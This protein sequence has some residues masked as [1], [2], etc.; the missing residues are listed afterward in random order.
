MIVLDNYVEPE[1]RIKSGK[2]IMIGR[3]EIMLN[4]FDYLN[5]LAKLPTTVLLRGETGTGKELCAKAL[6]YNGD[7]FRSKNE[8]VVVNCAGIPSELL[9]SELFGYV[10]GAFTGAYQT[11][12]GKFQHANGGTIFLDEIGDM[13]LPLQSKILRVIQE[14]QVIRIGSNKTEEIDVRIVTATNN[15]LE[16]KM[17]TGKFRKD[18]YFRLNVAPVT[19]PLLRDRSD[20]IPLI[21]E[22]F[23]KKYNEIH[24]SSL[25]GFS[26][27]AIER[28]MSFEWNGNVRELENVVERLFVLN[29][30]GIIHADDLCFNSDMPKRISGNSLNDNERLWFED[31]VY[32]I[33]P[34]ELS[35]L[36]GAMPY[37]C[38]RKRINNPRVHFT[39]LNTTK[40]ENYFII[41]LTPENIDLFFNDRTT[42]DY[43]DLKK[44]VVEDDFNHVVNHP[45][46]LFSISDL[47][48]N[49]YTL[50]HKNSLREA[51]E[52]AQAY[53]FF[54][55][56]ILCL[57]LNEENSIHFIPKGAG[58][59]ERNLQFHRTYIRP[60]YEKFRKNA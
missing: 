39:R 38:V 8:F 29:H 3:T 12:K 16:E 55:G 9:E 50:T 14:K 30:R 58:R 6:H 56:P 21:A 41:Y 11:T 51:A 22:H 5:H 25:G 46:A 57:A 60:S 40:K 13:P 34:R 23:L 37:T 2:G 28:L 7:R 20:D 53:K 10:K 27:D 33:S 36:D 18:L 52:K 45:F 32:P 19:I 49:P 15:R 35:K 43:N 1:Y 31:G 4:L 47:S 42:R 17:K 26:D 24:N 54:I 59:E 48:A 44:M